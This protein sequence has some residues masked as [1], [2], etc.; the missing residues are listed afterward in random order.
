[1]SSL[2]AEQL[3]A[4]LKDV[5]VHSKNAIAA[6]AARGAL[7]ESA[8]IT[9]KKCFDEQNIKA[10]VDA[11]AS[12]IEVLAYQ[13]FDPAVTLKVLLEKHEKLLKNSGKPDLGFDHTDFN[14]VMSYSIS[15]FLTRGTNWGNIKKKSLPMLQ[16]IMD[17][18]ANTYSIRT[19]TPKEKA[20]PQPNVITLSRIAASLP[21]ITVTLFSAGIHGEK[22]GESARPTRRTDAL[23]TQRAARPLFG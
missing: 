7:T 9:L 23:S 16:K 12:N 17:Y 1:M 13:G 22:F 6:I 14:S 20:A 2:Q 4:L 8:V 10:C 3:E 18:L 21:H 19:S 15:I 5:A 11:I